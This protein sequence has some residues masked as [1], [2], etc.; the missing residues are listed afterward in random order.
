MNDLKERPEVCLTYSLI[1]DWL[2]KAMLTLQ[3]LGERK[4]TV[5]FTTN[6]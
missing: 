4:R 3:S 6:Y 5:L 1:T 2:R